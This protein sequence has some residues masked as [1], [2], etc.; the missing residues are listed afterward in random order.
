MKFIHT[1]WSKPLYENLVK[2]FDES[3]KN[4]L[5][6]YACSVSCIHKFNE[7]I[8]LYTDKKGA[9]LLTFLPYDDIIIIEDKEMDE[10]SISFPAQMKF[11]ALRDCELG[12]VIIDGDLFLWKQEAIDIVKEA[13][14]DV[15]YSFFEPYLCILT[16][17][18]YVIICNHLLHKFSILE[19]EI[20]PP[21]YLPKY[22]DE[23]EY[24]N[25]S[26]MKINNQ[27]LKDKYV[28]DYF[29]YREKYKKVD[30]EN[31]WADLLIEQLFLT[32]L[33]KNKNYTSKPIIKN[34]FINHEES[35]N[36]AR[37]IGFV[38]LGSNKTPY[39][40]FTFN[41]LSNNDRVLC[42]KVAERYN[43]IIKQKNLN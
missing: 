11:Y 9:E 35:N 34:F 30:F 15:V 4:I 25:T 6:N 37:Q 10:T 43:E 24:F 12:D 23:Y 2:G 41:I 20:E 32:Q 39:F 29:L 3:L 22:P 13:K 5:Y 17:N 19:H 7:K 21:Y 31:V 8:V 1:F 14:E 40:D 42:D 16:Q 36:Y 38:H 28:N 27:E 18:N 33:V 26:L